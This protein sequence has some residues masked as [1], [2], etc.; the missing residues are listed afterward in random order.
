[1]DLKRRHE[2]LIMMM[3]EIHSILDSN[4]IHYMLIY[5]SALGA[6]RHKGIIPWDDDIDI[7]ILR[8]ELEKAEEFL[9][10]QLI[11]L[12]ERSEKHLE[13]SAPIGHVRFINKEETDNIH[14]L[15]NYTTIDI[16]PIDKIPKDNKGIKKARRN[17]LVHDFSVYRKAPTNR[18]KLLYVFGK[19]A[20]FIMPNRILDMVQKRTYKKIV[21][22]QYTDYYLTHNLFASKFNYFPKEV[23][24]KRE[25]TSFEGMNLPIPQEYDK[26]LTGMYGDYMTPPPLDKRVTIHKS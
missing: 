3:K 14:G 22:F 19:I 1:M 17:A 21:C 10:N 18:G 7:G 2:E 26:Y 23:F 8:E 25:Y 15:K 24:Y 16:W 6:V 11:Y 4:D 20:L 13:P 12:F 9:S 5:G